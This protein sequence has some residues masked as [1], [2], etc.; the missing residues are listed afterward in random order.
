VEKPVSVQ[1]QLAVPLARCG[2]L[3]RHPLFKNRVVPAQT[4][5]EQLMEHDV[6]DEVGRQKTELPIQGDYTVAAATPP[7]P[8]HFPEFHG[9][10]T[11]R[12]GAGV[13]GNQAGHKFPQFLFT[14]IRQG[15]PLC[16]LS[17]RGQAVTCFI[18]PSPFLFQDRQG[19]H[20]TG[21]Y[22]HRPLLTEL[23][24]GVTHTAHPYTEGEPRVLDSEAIY[25]FNHI[26][27]GNEAEKP[28]YNTDKILF[29]EL[30]L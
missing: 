5:V 25:F 9:C 2:K 14:A 3:F 10:G 20:A 1:F 6:G 15:Q 21:Q 12:Q 24:A 18:D 30:N 7:T 4:Q 23:D 19:I 29:T 13:F 22:Q 28:H 8:H 26:P 27:F 16:R 11:D 17:L